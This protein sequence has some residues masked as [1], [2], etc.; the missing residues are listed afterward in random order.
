M[1]MAP[2][3]AGPI[4]SGWSAAPIGAIGVY[5]AIFTLYL[6]VTRPLDVAHL[7]GLAHL[8]ALVVVQIGIC[9]ALFELGRMG[10]ALTGALA[11]PLWLPIGL[12]TGAAALGM[13]RYRHRP[14]LD[15]V[16]D[17]AL[18][19]ITDFHSFSGDADSQSSS[20]ARVTEALRARL[21]DASI[22]AAFAP[23][24]F[25]TIEA[26]NPA[27]TLQV[28]LADFREGSDAFDLA[29]LRYL[30]RPDVWPAQS[31]ESFVA[32]CIEGGLSA[33]HPAVRAE[34]AQ[35]VA[36]LMDKGAPQEAM[37]GADWFAD[38]QPLAPDVAPIAARIHRYIGLGPLH[39]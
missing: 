10:A 8:G 26:E 14:E 25:D 13:H 12:A 3:Y 17:D 19:A 28:L 18:A 32:L 6:I 20:V 37:P 23:D 30:A 21:W 16:L 9:S 34:A 11:L 22:E 38:A 5:T 33:P 36:M 1:V 7:S 15:K 27:S 2:L 35:I 39:S 31:H 4:L 24:L 29:L